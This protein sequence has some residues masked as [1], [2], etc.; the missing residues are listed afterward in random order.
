MIPGGDG[1]S[2]GQTQRLGWMIPERPR[3]G[4]AGLQRTADPAQR[5]PV[6][7]AGDGHLMTIGPTG[8]GKGRAALIPT[9]LSYPGSLIVI[10]PKGEIA[11]V[12]ARRRRELGQSVYFLDPF[13][14]TDFP[15]DRL[16]PLDLLDLPGAQLDCDSEMIAAQLNTGH[17]F[18]SDPYWNDTSRSLISGL[19][20]LEA[21]AKPRAERSLTSVRQWF[22]RH[23]MDYDVA[24]LLDT[25]GASM[26]AKAREALVNYLQIPSDKTR[27]CVRSSAETM[28]SVFGSQAVARTL[29]QSTIPLER[30]YHGDPLTVYLIIP[31]DKLV[32]HASL[33]RLW[34]TTLLTTIGRRPRIPQL[35]T[36]CLIDEAAQLGSLDSLETAITLL[37]GSGLTV[38]TFWQDVHQLE[39]AYPKSWKTLINNCDVLQT[40]GVSRPFLA[41]QWAD[42]L[43]C[44]ASEL[45]NLQPNQQLLTI[46]GTGVQ[47]VTKLDYLTDPE[48]QGLFDNNPLFPPGPSTYFQPEGPCR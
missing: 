18:E 48:Y 8:S 3:P 13:G 44:P 15:G 38:W 30:L 9:A 10:D 33:L 12:T 25:Q 35:R 29:Q 19:I 2:Q 16:D 26:H 45:M 36:L 24:V 37:R 7:Y 43:D 28:L 6:A 40:F 14:K 5:V 32:S 11:S 20:A 46:S 21:S 17:N 34:L 31:P 22:Y 42:V 47:K 4:F 39:K 27:P 23:E 1:L 41:R